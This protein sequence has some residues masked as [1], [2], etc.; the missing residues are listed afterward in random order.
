MKT[1]KHNEGPLKQLTVS[2]EAKVVEDFERMS[3]NSNLS[4]DELVLI[5]LKRFRS[6][7]SDYLKDVPKIE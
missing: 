6:S 5:A 1:Q 2:I 3:L 4:M 7:H